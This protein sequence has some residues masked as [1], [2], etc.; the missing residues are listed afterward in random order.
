VNV[1]RDEAEVQAIVENDG[2]VYDGFGAA[3]QPH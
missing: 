3:L 2:G 1:D